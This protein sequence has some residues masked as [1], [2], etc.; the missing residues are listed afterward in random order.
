MDAP[1]PKSS[2]YAKKT[3]AI[4]GSRSDVEEA[5]PEEPED[6]AEGPCSDENTL[7]IIE[8]EGGAT[9]EPPSPEGDQG[10]DDDK[11]EPEEEKE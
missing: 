11:E 4:I 9:L 1:L 3:V 2:P 7:V 6:D 10:S 5:D 8:E